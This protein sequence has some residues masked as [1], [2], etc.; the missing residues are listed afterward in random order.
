MG[1]KGN[2]MKETGNALR[3]R[4]TEARY[5]TKGEVDGKPVVLV[6]SRGNRDYATPEEI[7]EDLYGKKVEK[8]VFEGEAAPNA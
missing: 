7:L 8:V 2:S 4:R 1:K 6:L 3:T 5:G